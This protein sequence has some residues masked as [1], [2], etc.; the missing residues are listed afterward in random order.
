MR[1]Q[2][3]A[4]RG[5]TLLRPRTGTLKAKDT[6]ASVLGKNFFQA[7]SKKV[8]KKIFARVTYVAGTFI[9]KPKP[10]I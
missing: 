5:R 4:F 9:F 7:I 1:V 6:G 2:G 8:F 3:Q 10:T